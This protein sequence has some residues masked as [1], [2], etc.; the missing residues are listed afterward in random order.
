MRLTADQTAQVRDQLTEYLR[1]HRYLLPGGRGS[2]KSNGVRWIFTRAHTWDFGPDKVF[3][4]AA[5]DAKH[6]V[7]RATLAHYVARWEQKS[8]HP[9]E[10]RWGWSVSNNA[11]R[12]V[13]LA[14]KGASRYLVDERDPFW[15]GVYLVG[16]L[17]AGWNERGP[18]RTAYNR[19]CVRR[20]EQIARSEMRRKGE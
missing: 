5:G 12:R 17:V 10:L 8:F 18:A 7:R 6:V 1:E 3:D 9:P 20:L 15:G 2:E 19:S 11:A 4:W 16:D 13:D 14:P